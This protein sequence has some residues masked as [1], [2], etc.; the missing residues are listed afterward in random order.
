M[1][2]GVASAQSRKASRTVSCIGSQTFQSQAAVSCEPFPSPISVNEFTHKEKTF[3]KL[4]E[5]V[6]I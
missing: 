4:N 1:G 6:E 5:R 2:E 3:Q